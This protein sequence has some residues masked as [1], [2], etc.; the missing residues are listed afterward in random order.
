MKKFTLKDDTSDVLFEFMD[1]VHQDK[2]IDNL[3]KQ[4]KKRYHDL[5]KQSGFDKIMKDQES[6]EFIS[7]MLDQHTEDIDPNE[8]DI[9][10]Y[11]WYN[12]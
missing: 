1:I 4:L 7:G 2:Q 11:L 10:T 12:A 8:T 6:A 9:F 5:E 3:L